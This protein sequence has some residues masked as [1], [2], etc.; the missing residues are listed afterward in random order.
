MSFVATPK[1]IRKSVIGSNHALQGPFGPKPIVYADSTASGRSLYFIENYIQD[2]VLPFYANT[3]TE[4]SATG[5]QTTKF[6]ED[7]RNCIRR[8]LRAPQD[9]FAVIF[10]GSGSTGAMNK[11]ANVL[12]ISPLAPSV[13]DSSKRA[14]VFISAQEHHSNELLWRESPNTDC[15]VI[16]HDP[17]TGSMDQVVLVQELIK[18]QDRPLKLAS[19]SAASK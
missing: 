7:S 19:F 10:T 8:A 15:V 12:G 6:R 17:S 9:E 5:L 4:A 2:C 13:E 16:P 11:L 3:H 14:V 1:Q 18:Y